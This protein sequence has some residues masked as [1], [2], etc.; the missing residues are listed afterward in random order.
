ML[1]VISSSPDSEPG[2]YIHLLFDSADGKYI[3]IYIGSSNEIGPRVLAHIADR[4]RGKEYT[5]LGM[6]IMSASILRILDS[7]PETL[8]S[9][10]SCHIRED[11]QEKGRI[12]RGPST[13]SEHKG[14]LYY[15]LCCC[16]E[17]C[18]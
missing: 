18:L 4:K 14:T 1:N 5:K 11:R 17:A 10:S 6:K 13:L 7:G 8:C 3:G 16:S 2:V 12:A 15:A 9:G